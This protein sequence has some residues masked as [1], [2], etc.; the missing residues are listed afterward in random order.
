MVPLRSFQS[1]MSTAALWLKNWGWYFRLPLFQFASVA[2]GVQLLGL[3]F[4]GQHIQRHT[5]AHKSG[6]LTLQWLSAD[7]N[8]CQWTRDK[9]EMS[10]FLYSRLRSSGSVLDQRSR[11]ENR[12]SRS[13]K[14][15]LAPPSFGT[16]MFVV[17]HP[18]M[19][20]VHRRK[21]FVKKKSALTP[22]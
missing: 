3:A 20:E 16:A 14:Q 5:K 10:I 1:V 4:T 15:V 17:D 9:W 19:W 6:R 13:P 18:D 21:S 12:N 11:R 2:T 8:L 22:G 7:R